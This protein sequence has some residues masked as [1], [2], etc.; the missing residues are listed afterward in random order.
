MS[1]VATAACLLLLWTP[2]LTAGVA[3]GRSAGKPQIS[4]AFQL[5]SVSATGSKRYTPQQIA[6][7]SGL[8]AG[9]MVSE[10]DFKHVAQELADTGA[11]SQV[12]YT[13]QYTGT[14]V[15]LELQVVDS[16]MFVP[17]QF[18]NFVWFSDQQLMS[19]LQGEV[20]LFKGELPITGN[21]ADQVSTALQGMLI[22]SKVNGEVDYLRAAAENGPVNAIVFSV[23]GP[24]ITIRSASFTGAGPEELALLNSAGKTLA[25]EGYERSILQV[26]AEK[27][28]LPIF[29]ERGYLK[30]S[31]GEAEAKVVQ[32]S[33][34]ETVVDVSF[35]V[36]PGRQYKLG[37][38]QWSGNTILPTKQLQSAL[39]GQ[40]GQ[41]ANAIQLGEDLKAVSKLYGAR[42]YVAAVVRSQPQ[43]DDA[44]ATVSY[45]LQ[46]HEGDMYHMGEL[47]IR[48]LDTH[49][50]DRLVLAWQLRQGQPYDAS[51]A[52]Q[53]LNDAFRRDLVGGGWNISI[54]ES[55]DPR[56]KTVDVTIQF[57]SKT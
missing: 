5:G 43:F 22:E 18:D 4:N 29:L 7:A 31:F 55:P 17:A 1:S 46:V 19:K 14:G 38:V 44:T 42:G 36:E 30:A 10:D 41:P 54:H 47:E 39:H 53:F 9:E 24:R 32:Q 20:P 3:S 37:R 11:F 40:P 16:K 51:Y 50:T 28:F 35:A 13:Y 56:T 52:K 45:S 25:G 57:S 8:K 49:D 23:S 6:A 2:A 48:G 27:N 26:Q 12:A 33:P 34:D 15:K 21:L